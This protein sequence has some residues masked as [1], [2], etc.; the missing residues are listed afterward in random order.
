MTELTW[1]T[2][3]FE[4]TNGCEKACKILKQNVVENCSLKILEMGKPFVVF[5]DGSGNQLGSLLSQERRVSA[6]E[7]RKFCSHQWNYPIL[8]LELAAMTHALKH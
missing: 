4:W 3:V 8:C 6:Y 7:S 5:C 2:K 1:N